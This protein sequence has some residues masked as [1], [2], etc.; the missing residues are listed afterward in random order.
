MAAVVQAMLDETLLVNFKSFDFEICFRQTLNGIISTPR[1]VV[2]VTED[3]SDTDA[4]FEP[5]ADVVKT[6]TNKVIGVSSKR[7]QRIRKFA[8][9]AEKTV[10]TR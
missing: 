9:V 5:V 6:E 8:R 7:K 10:S 1:Y 2:A 4:F 3:L